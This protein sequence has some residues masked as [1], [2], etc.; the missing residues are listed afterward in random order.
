MALSQAEGG[1][2]LT[3]KVRLTG[4]VNVPI[5]GGVGLVPTPVPHGLSFNKIPPASADDNSSDDRQSDVTEDQEGNDSRN[6]LQDIQ[7]HQ[8]PQGNKST[9]VRQRPE[10]E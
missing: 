1:S 5:A 10:I 2:S 7:S 4:H 6:I 9:P 3:T 8:S